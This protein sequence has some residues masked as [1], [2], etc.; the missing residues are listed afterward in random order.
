[1]HSSSYIRRYANMLQKVFLPVLTVAIF[2]FGVAS[3]VAQSSQPEPVL[4]FAWNGNTPTPTHLGCLQITPQGGNMQQGQPGQPGQISPN[5][6][7][8]GSQT[9]SQPNSTATGLPG[10]GLG[11][12]G[13]N[14]QTPGYNGI[15]QFGVSLD[16]IS[17]ALSGYAYA[18]SHPDPSNPSNATS[19]IGWISFNP[20][21]VSG[22]PSAPCAPTVN[23][24]TGK[25]TGWMRVCSVFNSGCSGSYH[26][27]AGGWDG[28]V[29]LSDNQYHISPDFTANGGV[30]YDVTT[31]DYCGYAWGGP[32]GGWID[33]GPT[34]S[35]PPTQLP[36]LCP[37]ITGTQNPIP[38]GLT[39]DSNGDCVT[40]G[41]NGGS[42]KLT[43]QANPQTD[44]TSPYQTTLTW[45]SP[46]HT[47]YSVCQVVG[48]TPVATGWV[49]G[50]TFGGLS[51]AN[52]WTGSTT[53]NSV[54][55]PSPIGSST[56]YTIA[57][58]DGTNTD[59]ATTNAQRGNLTAGVS[60]N[61]PSCM[62]ISPP[63]IVT[64]SWSTT[65]TDMGTC[66]FSSSPSNTAWNT[67]SVSS[68]DDSGSETI[69]FA[70]FAPGVYSFM[71]DCDDINGNTLAQGITS[72]SYQAAQCATGPGG[73]PRPIFEE[74]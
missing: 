72:V 59:T 30:S 18:G 63:D 9:Q 19:G 67:Q 62:Q 68:P 26:A 37:N 36:D 29:H 14:S 34:C 20:G 15:V 55:I 66:S 27:Q 23:L 21:D 48:S 74:N 25:V 57:C 73:A 54:S 41:T 32:V 61:G 12:I 47:N 10:C 31:G 42:S 22:C 60:V 6:T 52:N 3:I 7:Q 35:A 17:G 49:A 58:V 24:T 45:Y 44:S 70:S 43:L 65:N 11:W 33:F 39:L 38:S 2:G 13:M 50:T 53:L 8:S 46:T 69:D 28:W 40:G 56:A 16:M 4:G 64:I 5:S 71:L 1:M 51:P